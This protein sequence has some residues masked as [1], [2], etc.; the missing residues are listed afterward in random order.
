VTALIDS[1]EMHLRTLYELREEGVLSM[2]ARLVERLR[3]S[4]PSV[5]ETTARLAT[6]GLVE[7][8][9]DR[10]VH[11]TEKGL[12]RAAAVMRKHRLAELLL[13]DVI[14]LDWRLVHNE[15][16]R[17][18]HVISDAVSD[19]LTVLLGNPQ[20]CPHGNAIPPA[21]ALDPEP[22][23]SPVS[24]LAAAKDAEAE[25]TLG[26]MSE[27]LQT[28]EELMRRLQDAGVLPGAR[29]RIQAT[30]DGVRVCRLAAGDSSVSAG[31]ELAPPVAAVLFVDRSQP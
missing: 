11:L 21:A 17:W 22:A 14:G 30:P 9:S 28:D 5:S 20:H 18:E 10:T 24:L 16:C 19:R 12:I 2:R 6:D 13:T 15:A 27:S 29:L 8:S 3:L 31:L 23:G 4:A 1:T 25:V 7:I 26:W